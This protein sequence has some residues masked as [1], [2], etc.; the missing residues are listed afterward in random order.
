MV[1]L[2][3]SGQIRVNFSDSDLK[4][5]IFLFIFKS[6]LKCRFGGFHNS[7]TLNFNLASELQTCALKFCY[8]AKK[9][10]VEELQIHK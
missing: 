4:S 5:L 6:L 2:K 9:E 8:D 7:L 3:T 1:F 10:E